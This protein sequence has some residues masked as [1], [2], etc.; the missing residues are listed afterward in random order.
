MCKTEKQVITRNV[1]PACCSKRIRQVGSELCLPAILFPVERSTIG[2]VPS[3]AIKASVCAECSHIFLSEIDIDFTE[4]LY[5]KYYH[6]YPF[7]G[8]E[9]LNAFYRDPF[10]RVADVF[11]QKG[12]LSLLEIGCEDVEQMRYFIDLGYNC[13]AINPSIAQSHEVQFING[14]YGKKSIPGVFDRIIA[15]FNLE[16]IVDMERFLV[17]ISANLKA[18]GVAII[19][20]PNAEYFLRLGILNILAHEHAHYFCRNSLSLLMSR[21]GFEIQYLSRSSEPSLICA[22]THLDRNQ[23]LPDSHFLSS[24]SVIIEVCDFIRGCESKINIYGAGLSLTAILYSPHF[25][26]D[27]FKKINLFD[28][29]STIQG[30]LM[31]NTPL[32]I[33]ALNRDDLISN[34]PV[35]LTLSEQYHPAIIKRLTELD[36][37][38]AIHAITGHGFHRV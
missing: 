2:S 38:L 1:C 26:N 11:C 16:H 31:P 19:Q 18:D 12:A 28:D 34:S 9:T 13:T 37:D 4:Q 29:N 33:R 15:R 27:W 30:R 7:K 35:L 5:R 25:N 17:E 10:D 20:V 6:L 24:D 14:F 8:L 32:E 22:V 3:A 23:Y 36:P 21:H